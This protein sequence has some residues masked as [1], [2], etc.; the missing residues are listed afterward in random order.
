MRCI[1]HPCLYLKI[2]LL[3]LVTSLFYGNALAQLSKGGRPRSLLLNNLPSSSAEIL[4]PQLDHKAL[5]EQEAKESRVGKPFHFGHT[6]DVAYSTKNSGTW[7]ELPNGD[8]IWRLKLISG[9]AFSLNLTFS[10]FQLH[11]ES[12]LFIFNPKTEFIIGAFDSSNNQTDKVFGTGLVPGSEVVVELFEPLASRNANLLTIGQVTHAYKNVAGFGASGACQ[13]N[14]NCPLG[15]EWQSEKRAVVIIINGGDWCTGTLLNN[16]RQDGKPYFLTASH[17]FQNNLSSWVFY[18][19]W[20]SPG[21]E[22]VNIPKT[23]SISGSALVARNPKS[24][25]LLLELSQK[26]PDAFTPFYAGW[27]AKPQPSQASLCIHHPSGDIKKISIDQDSVSSSAYQNPNADDSTHWRVGSWDMNTATE[28]GSSGSP[29]F[30]EN[31]Q[32][33]GQLNG[34]ESACGIA[35]SDYFGKF[36]YSW[37]KGATPETRLKDWLDPD[38]TGALELNGID[39]ACLIHLTFFPKKYSLDSLSNLLPAWKIKNPDADSTWRFFNFSPKGL[40]IN[41]QWPGA[42][43]KQDWLVLPTSNF[44]RWGKVKVKFRYAY[45]YSGNA[46]ADSLAFKISFNCGSSYKTVWQKGGKQL[47]TVPDSS[48]TYFIPNPAQWKTDSIVF[49]TMLDFRS[50]VRMA[51]VNLSAGGQ[52]I[53]LDNLEISAE[54]RLPKPIASFTFSPSIACVDATVSFANTSINTGSVLWSFPGG[55]PSSSTANNPIVKYSQPGRYAVSLQVKNE[56]GTNSKFLA[57]AVYIPALAQGNFPNQEDFSGNAFPANQNLI[58]NADIDSTW[59]KSEFS[60]SLETKGSMVVNNYDYDAK[61]QLDYFLL[62]KVKPVSGKSLVMRFQYAYKFFDSP[63]SQ[64]YDTLMVAYT[65]NCGA[66]FIPIWKKGGKELA[67]QMPS[68]GPFFP[69][70]GDWKSVLLN[71]DSLKNQEE[72]WLALVNK[73]GY[74]NYLYVDEIE[75]DT[76]LACPQGNLIDST[77]IN[78]CLG[79]SLSIL[80]RKYLNATYT[81]KGPTG[82]EWNAQNI[83]LDQSNALLQGKFYLICARYFCAE[84]KDSVTVKVLPKPQ[85]PIMQIVGPQ[86]STASNATYSYQWFLNNTPIVGAR[87]PFFNA[88][89]VGEYFVQVRNEAGCSASSAKALVDLVSVKTLNKNDEVA[90]FPNP[91]SD[92]LIIQFPENS[93][94]NQSEWHIANTLG[95][96]MADGRLTASKRVEISTQNWPKGVYFLKCINS[97]GLQKTF[98][99]VK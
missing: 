72:V 29:L 23:Q 94:W 2:L 83:Q 47:A 16:V 7:T 77:E 60:A 93:V 30:N 69:E 45:Q 28:N 44:V 17:C 57:N 6:F 33:V 9:N 34:G 70:T 68:A 88:S 35:K 8:R 18:F 64:N 78:N 11:G 22:S 25:F 76:S 66:T 36:W 75:L 5:L 40:C 79:D 86:L 37:D 58:F 46:K 10:A 48:T 53:Y 43:G 82:F 81:W 52:P 92:K 21:C 19:N 67:N 49:D 20:E 26:P 24:D 74:G 63:F 50:S 32:V 80:A 85:V 87:N 27:N 51:F 3:L 89:T 95:Q 4:L 54:P 91:F 55:I 15:N 1:F 98:Q 56:S 97:N 38:N 14:V 62:P 12:D 65:K 61:G 73:C 84:A 39:S 59:R 41:N 31:H 90:F 71:L 96:I 42:S 13:I 99:I